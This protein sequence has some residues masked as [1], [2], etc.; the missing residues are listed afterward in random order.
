[1]QQGWLCSRG[2]NL[3]PGNLLFVLLVT[4]VLTNCSLGN[5]GNPASGPTPLSVYIGTQPQTGN[6]IVYALRADNGSV[7]W[8][9]KTHTSS[10]VLTEAD[11]IVYAA[12]PQS[13]SSLVYALRA[14]DG[15][16]LWN[17]SINNTDVTW[18]LLSGGILYAA[19]FP[20]G[21]IYGLRA[22]DSAVLW[23]TSIS[24]A[25]S[26]LY[27]PQ[28]VDGV[29]YVVSGLD[30]A[31][32]AIHGSDGSIRWHFRTKYNSTLTSQVSGG[33]LYAV[34]A[35]FP[36]DS[37]KETVY[38]LRARDGAELWHAD[39]RPNFFSA[40]AFSNGIVYIS[41]GDGMLYAL[42]AKNGSLLWH[43][44]TGSNGTGQDAPLV[45]NGVV[46]NSDPVVGTVTAL[47]ASNGAVQWS[48]QTQ[49]QGVSAPQLVNGILYVI[50]DGNIVYALQ[51]SDG[52][53]IWSAE[54]DKTPGPIARFF[55]VVNGIIYLV[56]SKTGVV[57]ALH[58]EDG[59]R[60]WRY[61][62]GPANSDE[63]LSMMVG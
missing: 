38:A 41:G 55:S 7:R 10:V 42:Q 21:I 25:H 52:T 19:D 54:T 57:Y 62:V 8:Q 12:G 30:G 46:Y 20:D 43:M 49:G 28:V 2:W 11:G 17:V 23:H 39:Q 44:K 58:V 35:S 26:G 14:S 47:R 53:I 45:I 36:P 51:P 63:L 32:Y 5:R 16:M 6:G 59:T 56:D 27:F 1:M 22:K 24:N 37:L 48:A 33:I 4:L 50:G 60:V 34:S 29:F 61:T 40:P 9:Y 15:S 18:L 31:I 3:L 13:S